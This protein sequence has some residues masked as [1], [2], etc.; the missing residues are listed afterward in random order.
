M[1]AAAED[2]AVWSREFL[3]SLPGDDESW[4]LEQTD[5]DGRH[6]RKLDNP[7]F[8]RN[9]F[10][11]LATAPRL[12]ELVTELIGS[13][14]QI[15]FSQAFLKPPGTGSPKPV[16]QDNFY[17]GTAEPDHVL[18][19]WIAIDDAT[20]ENGC[21]CFSEG[22]HRQPVLPH[23]A[24]PGEPFNLQ[25]LP[26]SAAQ[27]EMTP[28]PV[29]RGGVSFHHGNTLH[30]SG[31]NRSDVPRR[32]VAVHFLSRHN[33]LINPALDYDSGV[34]VDATPQTPEAD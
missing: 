27:F 31:E 3:Q 4:F 21:L 28:A 20:L 10:R 17:F 25:V 32:A 5:V 23:F 12:L 33:R 14:L 30:Q 13:P 2:L 6:L 18:T 1:L 34:C 24:P 15:F 11:K 16:H 9:V 29:A 8:H 22:S 7:V 19:A 26:E